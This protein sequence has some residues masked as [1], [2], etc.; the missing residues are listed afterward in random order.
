VARLKLL[1]LLLLAIT[2]AGAGAGVLVYRVG[3]PAPA[4]AVIEPRAPVSIPQGNPQ[5]VVQAP[6]HPVEDRDRLQGT[7]SISV[8]EQEGRGRP[9]LRGRSLVFTEDRFLLG[10][11]RAEVRGIIPSARLEGDYTLKPASPGRIDLTS[12]GWHLH[13]IYTLEGNRL[14]LCL[15]ETFVGERPTE[16]ATRPESRQLLLVLERE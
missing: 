10:A 13:G 4:E 8:A 12:R 5:P 1:A 11:W 3:T 16:F 14:T 6:L 9:E 7:W 2:A 15:N